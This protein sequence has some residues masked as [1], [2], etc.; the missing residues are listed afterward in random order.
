[1]KICFLIPDGVGIRNYL[2][3]DVMKFLSKKG[4]EVIVWH[5][6]GKEQIS[7]VRANIGVE[8]EDYEFIH[9]AE[10]P[11]VKF[12]RESAV[13]ARLKKNVL[14]RNNPSIL[15]NW[16]PNKIGFK[17]RLFY[18]FVEGTSKFLS[19]FQSIYSFEKTGFLLLRRSEAYKNS[20]RFLGDSKPDILF[21]THQ[22][23]PSI[24]AAVEAAKDLNIKTFTA[25]FSWDN[26]PK[27][28]LAFRTDKYLVWSPYMR[29]ELITYYPE[30]EGNQIEV[31][32]T[33]Q[34]DFYRNGDLIEGKEKFAARYGLD[35]SKNWICYSGSD[36]ISS[37]NDPEYLED[38]AQAL[39][40]QHQIQ[41]IFREV[42]I[43]SIDRFKEVLNKYPS[44][45]NISPEWVKG[46]H[47][48]SFFPLISD[49]K[50]L[51]NLAYH[52]GI[53]INLGSTMALDFAVFES[54][55]FYLNYDQPHEK[56][57][58]VKE[59]YNYEHF[60]TMHGLNAVGWINSKEEI[61][62]KILQA[63]QNPNSFGPDR[64]KWFQR[65]VSPMKDESSAER[66]VK[67]L[68]N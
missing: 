28:R 50:L 46:S 49:I 9:M 57:R 59:I 22:R 31:T 18:S 19:T 68:L 45:L 24:T 1:M 53:V 11:T 26:L 40:N 16:K 32:S 34:F 3:S 5:S 44:I 29:D 54:S 13:L 14:I 61:L 4:N 23:V 8:F 67:A 43:E 51:V 47:W 17:N 30:I 41:I 66:I 21:C 36:I 48:G 65:V 10:L 35:P 63:L 25:V 15:D 42:P 27:A 64:N 60:K 39:Q 20:L 2:Y 56:K 58:F 38:I 6:L 55:A 7:K 12:I 33:T 37:P 52:C 62:P